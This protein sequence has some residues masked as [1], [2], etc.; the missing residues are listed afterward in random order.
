MSLVS[1]FIEDAY[2]LKQSLFEFGAKCIWNF[3]LELNPLGSDQ[4]K[5]DD[6]KY[7][8]KYS[9]YMN[10]KYIKPLQSIIESN[11]SII[12]S[13]NDNNNNI[14][15]EI[16]HKIIQFEIGGIEHH[17]QK[18][19][20][21]IINSYF[22]FPILFGY[23][24][25][26][27]I[28]IFCVT[29]IFYSNPNAEYIPLSLIIFILSFILSII[30]L[31][32]CIISFYKCSKYS[33]IIHKFQIALFNKN[34]QSLPFLNDNCEN[35]LVAYLPFQKWLNINDFELNNYKF[36]H[37][38]KN[39]PILILMLSKYWMLA[40]CQFVI[41]L[42]KLLGKIYH[43]SQETKT[44]LIAIGVIQCGLVLFYCHLRVTFLR[45][46]HDSLWYLLSLLSAISAFLV[47]EI[48]LI[49]V[50]EQFVTH[51][52]FD[53]SYDNDD[54][55]ISETIECDNHNENNYSLISTFI[56][57]FIP[58]IISD[59]YLLFDSIFDQYQ[60]YEIYLVEQCLILITPN[61]WSFFIYI[62]IPIFSL[63]LLI[64]WLW[65]IEYGIFV[66]SANSILNTITINNLNN[67]N[68][69]NVSWTIKGN[70]FDLYYFMPFYRI[71]YLYLCFVYILYI[72]V[73]F[74]FWLTSLNFKGFLEFASLFGILSLSSIV[75]VYTQQ[76]IHCLMSD[77]NEYQ[78]ALKYIAPNSIKYLWKHL[79]SIL[80]FG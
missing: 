46:I 2:E 48:I 25:L 55:V 20:N 19:I 33:Y 47:M 14:P 41:I 63:I 37:P 62:F 32:G 15:I 64:G 40:Y 11:D 21:S 24:Q 53:E 51:F 54:V 12:S 10:V 68:I 29:N 65:F 76:Q 6:G 67:L 69:S 58:S 72:G 75:Y 17:Y 28:I 13:I 43:I 38:S 27:L 50:L 78:F 60:Q 34:N 30:H 80:F 45:T 66:Q 23:L 5:D 57:P 71:L 59:I 56:A 1:S 8:E 74:E 79:K 31:F 36:L 39:W 16:Y 70:L 22:V 73:I 61:L 42:S 26:L 44:I 52:Q 18:Y 35:I 3:N 4:T 9:K 77:L 7:I 49:L